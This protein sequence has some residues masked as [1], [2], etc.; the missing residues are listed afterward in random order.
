[1][2]LGMLIVNIASVFIA[3]D[4]RVLKH[5]EQDSEWLSLSLAMSTDNFPFRTSFLNSA[6]TG[7][8]NYAAVAK[9]Q[10]I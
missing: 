9:N 6:S 7:P 3:A 10:I 8:P 4:D 2:Q 1:M 5:L